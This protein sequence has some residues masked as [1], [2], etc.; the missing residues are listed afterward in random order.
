MRSARPAG[1]EVYAG[2]DVW[3]AQTDSALGRLRYALSPVSFKGG[4]AG[5]ARP[6]GPWGA[7]AP[8]WS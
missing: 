7:D 5:W 6:S 3:P 8:R 4:P 2:P 1:D